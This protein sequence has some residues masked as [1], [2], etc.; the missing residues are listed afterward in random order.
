MSRRY[1]IMLLLVGLAGVGCAH[2]PSR[3]DGAVGTGGYFHSAAV[4]DGNRAPASLQ[5]PPNAAMIDQRVDSVSTRTRADYHYAMGEALSF[6]GQHQKAIEAF[7]TVLIYDQEA[8]S[9]HLRLAAEYVKLGMLSESLESAQ[10]AARL[11]P[12]SEDA[13]LLLGGLHSTLKDYDKAIE[14]YKKVLELN[15]DNTE[16]PMYLGAVYA[17]KKDYPKAVKYFEA[18]ARNEDYST[19]HMAY[20]YLGRIRTDQGGDANLKLA[21]KAY[22]NALEKKPDH[23]DSVLALGQLMNKQGRVMDAVTLYKNF[24][25]DQGPS[26][27]IAEIL[28][29]VYMEQDDYTNAL[30]QFEILEKRSDDALSVKVRIALML[31]ELKRYPQAADKLY[32]VLRQVP[33]SDKIR[34]YLAAVFEEMG[35]ADQAIEHFRKVPAASSF[36]SESVIHAAYLLK[37]KRRGDEALAVVEAAMK[38]KSDVPQFYSLAATLYDEKG[39]VAK[40]EST[41]NEGL[42][43]FPENVQLNFFLGT[44]YDRKGQKDKVITQ[45]RKVVNMDPQHV[46]GLNYLAFTFA[47]MGDNLDEAEDL[48]QRAIDL[49]PKDGFVLDTY[50]WILYK[51]GN[52]SDAITYLERAHQAQP[53][54]SIIAEHLGD[55]YFKGQM[56]EKARAMYERALEHADS[57]TRARDLTQKI[58]AMEIQ[59]QVRADGRQP[60][61]VEAEKLPM[62]PKLEK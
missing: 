47:E 31:I 8:S 9:V 39:D 36:Y 15:P 14:F 50:G 37:G 29:Q 5:P 3:N 45:M 10:T 2:S 40:A 22:R 4:D 44:V 27:K 19:P 34:F 17:E 59:F 6:D 12:K 38:E 25:R 43:Q 33:D 30:E 51:R 48:A 28:S 49:E 42:A 55:A 23:V 56:M 53:R 35:E 60:A 32:E 18:L 41:L 26:E 61:S 54:E 57:K 46:Q 1:K 24:Q 52:W 20:Y 62:K 7:K 11:D 13:L 21:A 58:T 16:A